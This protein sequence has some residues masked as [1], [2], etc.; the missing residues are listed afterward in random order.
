[1]L[2]CGGLKETLDNRHGSTL[3]SLFGWLID[4][5]N[6]KIVFDK[7]V[8]GNSFES[9]VDSIIVVVTVHN[10]NFVIQIG[11]HSG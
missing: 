2:I 4:G 11:G 9:V 5:H 6:F 10:K 3:K 1:M 7:R 8:M